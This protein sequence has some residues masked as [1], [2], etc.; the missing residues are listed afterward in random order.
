MAD[1]FEALA[2]QLFILAI[3]WHLSILIW[4]VLVFRLP[5]FVQMAPRLAQ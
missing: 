2:S 3:G 4:G 5:G 1:Y